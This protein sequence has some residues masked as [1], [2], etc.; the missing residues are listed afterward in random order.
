MDR[1]LIEMAVETDASRIIGITIL[2]G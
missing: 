1:Q 2:A